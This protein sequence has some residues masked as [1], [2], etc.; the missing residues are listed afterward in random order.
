MNLLHLGVKEM[1]TAIATSM[2][3]TNDLIG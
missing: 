2:A 3:Q 1:M